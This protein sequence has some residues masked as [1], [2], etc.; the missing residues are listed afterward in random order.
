MDPRKGLPFTSSKPDPYREG[1]AVPMG[2]R[3]SVLDVDVP[4]SIIHI[5]LELHSFFIHSFNV[6]SVPHR[7]GVAVA[8]FRP[9]R[10]NRASLNGAVPVWLWSEGHLRALL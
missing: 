10:F 1:P 2:P 6:S 5:H 7:D 8:A 9:V 3:P 4:M